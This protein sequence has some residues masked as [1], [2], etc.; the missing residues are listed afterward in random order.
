MGAFRMLLL[1]AFAA[2]FAAVLAHP[3]LIILPVQMLVLTGFAPDS[4]T[5]AVHHRLSQPDGILA[6]IFAAVFERT[7]GGYVPWMLGPDCLGVSKGEKVMEIGFGP[8]I[9]IEEALQRGARHVVGVEVSK[10]MIDVATERNAAAIAAGKVTMFHHEAGEVSADAKLAEIDDAKRAALPAGAKDAGPFDV[11]WNQN[12]IYFFKEKRGPICS[13]ASTLRQG[14]R[15]GI[16]GAAYDDM[17]PVSSQLSGERQRFTVIP[18]EQMMSIMR[19]CGLKDVRREVGTKTP[20]AM[21]MKTQC[22]VGTKK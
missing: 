17:Q 6:P 13:W 2:L 7:N 11:V 4:L 16:C 8:G 19:D 20:N 21:G 15:L 9:G 5:A 22:L 14:G 1:A 10:S 3:Y 12:V 18:D